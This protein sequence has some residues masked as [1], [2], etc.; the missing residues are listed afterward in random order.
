MECESLE[1]LNLVCFRNVPPPLVISLFTNIFV[2]LAMK[3]L[4]NDFVRTTKN[5]RVKIVLKN[6][7]VKSILTFCISKRNNYICTEFIA[8]NLLRKTFIQINIRTKKKLH[9]LKFSRINLYLEHIINF[10]GTT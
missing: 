9:L 8:V 10:Y 2:L 5:L 3:Q 4:V 6:S 7:F 1:D